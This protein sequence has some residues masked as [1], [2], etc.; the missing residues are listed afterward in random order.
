MFS[1]GDI[2]G[3]SH[4]FYS[5]RYTAAVV[6]DNG[7]FQ[8]ELMFIRLRAATTVL[9]CCVIKLKKVVSQPL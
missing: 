6:F 4:V 8:N 2:N 9:C 7:T 5:S 1:F 3:L